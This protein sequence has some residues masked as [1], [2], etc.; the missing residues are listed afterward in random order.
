MKAANLSGANMAQADL[1]YLQ[2]VQ[3]N[4]QGAIINLVNLLKAVVDAQTNILNAIMNGAIC[5]DGYVSANIGGT[6]RGHLTA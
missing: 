1:Q 5:P 6:C 2:A 3:A 4:F